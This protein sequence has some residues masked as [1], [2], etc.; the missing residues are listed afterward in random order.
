M[1]A[2][3]S[4][5]QISLLT[6]FAALCGID[7]Y[8]SGLQL[9]KP[10]IAGFFAG[11]IMGDIKTGLVIGATLQLMVL[12]VGTFGGSSIP[13]FASGA[14]IGTA[15][16]VVSGKGIQFAIGISVPVGLLLVQLD[17][18]AR[19]CNVYFAHRVDKHI[20]SEEFQKINTEAWLSLLPIGLSRALP[21]GISLFFGN[22]VVNTVL[23]YAPAWLMGGLKL[24]GAVL[25]V[26]GIAILLHYLPV[27]KF[28]AYLMIGYLLAAYFNM[29][30]MGIALAGT[31]CAMLHFNNIKQQQKQVELHQVQSKISPTEGL[32]EIIGDE[33]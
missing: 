19:F 7:P 30:M 11:V 13:D 21:V 23:K 2:N 3:L 6:I 10:V 17:I 22:S 32:E 27:G 18:L 9:S 4:I 15:L 24:A 33:I 26:V 25:P 20:E 14:I 16:G 28:F 8:I 31:A 29:P 5:T 1:V 12:G